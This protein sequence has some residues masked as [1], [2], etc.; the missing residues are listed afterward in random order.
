MY[1][2]LDDSQTY[3]PCGSRRKVSLSQNFGTEFFTGGGARGQ[4]VTKRFGKL[5]VTGAEK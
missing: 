4:I 2:H 3:E 1:F 5:F